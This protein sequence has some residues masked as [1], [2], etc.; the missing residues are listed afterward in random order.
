MGGNSQ[1][2]LD[3]IWQPILRP[4]QHFL[5]NRYYFRKQSCISFPNLSEVLKKLSK[6]SNTSILK[7]H[8][9]NQWQLLGN[10]FHFS[11]EKYYFENRNFWCPKKILDLEIN[12]Q[13]PRVLS[14][15]KLFQCSQKIW[16]DERALFTKINFIFTENAT[17]FAHRST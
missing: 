11:Q 12:F 9:H 4:K 14:F 17:W 2:F 16:K 15:L 7:I 1:Q 6:W 8:N 10:N 3:Q 13:N 5:N